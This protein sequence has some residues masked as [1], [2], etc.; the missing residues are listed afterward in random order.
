M[1]T[2]LWTFNLG[3]H[4]I[5]GLENELKP[6]IDPANGGLNDARIG[7]LIDPRDDVRKS[8]I[9]FFQNEQ[10]NYMCMDLFRRA[11]KECFNVDIDFIYD[12][13]YT[14][15]AAEREEHF[16]WHIDVDWGNPLYYDRKLS[17]T[18]QLSD[19]DEYEDGNLEFKNISTTEKQ[20]KAQRQKGWVC[21]FPSYLEHRV[22]MV[23]KGTRKSLVAWA[24]GPRWR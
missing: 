2:P 18:I 12:I 5:E 8:K 9:K 4:N 6:I 11:N 23:T 10:I 13:Q 16:D 22:T 7:Q 19:D 20:L 1:R 15:Y 21:V 14:E 17:M 3:K 24:E